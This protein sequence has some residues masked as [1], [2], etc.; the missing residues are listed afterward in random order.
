MPVRAEVLRDRTIGWEKTLRLTRGFDPPLPLPCRLMGSQRP[1]SQCGWLARLPPLPP[2]HLGPGS[3]APNIGDHSPSDSALAAAEIANL[4]R[5][6]NQHIALADAKRHDTI[7]VSIVSWTDST[8]PSPLHAR[9][10][11]AIHVMG[12]QTQAY[13]RSFHCSFLAT[14]L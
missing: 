12:E 13:N 6:D 4:E 2:D 5:R 9:R 3:L 1:V 7:T 14:P 10:G 11:N 8:S